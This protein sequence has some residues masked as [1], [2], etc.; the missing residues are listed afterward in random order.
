MAKPDSVCMTPILW[1]ITYFL[2]R[3]MT[4]VLQMQSGL[5]NISS[6]A[7]QLSILIRQRR[8]RS[9]H[10]GPVCC[11]Y[12]SNWLDLYIMSNKEGKMQVLSSGI[13]K[14]YLSKYTHF[15]RS[16]HLLCSL[17][18]S[19]IWLGGSFIPQVN[20]HWTDISNSRK[21]KVI[22]AVRLEGLIW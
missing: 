21:L 17:Q 19:S 12:H 1:L 14:P 4:T 10:L 18:C 22:N 6:V 9:L 15:K 8:N 7:L 13:T 5:Q 3:G 20:R 2:K 16:Q 11:N